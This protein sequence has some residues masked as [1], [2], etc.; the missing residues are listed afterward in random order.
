MTRLFA[1]SLV[2][3]LISCTVWAQDSLVVNRLDT[4]PDWL[5]EPDRGWVSPPDTL[6]PWRY[7]PLAVGNAWE[8]R[9]QNGE[10]RRVDVIRD[11]VIDEQL[12]FHWRAVWY[13][14]QGNQGSFIHEE[15]IRFDTLSSYIITDYFQYPFIPEIPCRFDG[16][17]EAPVDCMGQVG[18]GY[19]HWMT[20]EG[21]LAFDDTTVFNIPVKQYDDILGLIRYAAD[22]GEIWASVK[23]GRPTRGLTFARIDGQT[24]GTE[25]YPYTSSNEPDASNEGDLRIEALWPNPARSSVSVQLNVPDA[26]QMRIVVLDLLGREVLSW[27]GLIT[28]NQEIIRL[29]LSELAV[30]S[31][32]ARVSSRNQ[33]SRGVLFTRIE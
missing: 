31:Y 23:D 7:Y 10:T 8:Y 13:D 21:V 15:Y 30:G 1:I 29:N 26:R 9:N 14:S 25:L 4:H 19:V 6:D 5:F 22:F 18:G 2:F 27:E 3:L 32:I 33:I 11:L 24:F 16:Q 20:Y 28:R 17:P 12:Y